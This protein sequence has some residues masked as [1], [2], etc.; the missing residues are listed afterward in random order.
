MPV[1]DIHQRLQ[2]RSRSDNTERIT[3][4]GDSSCVTQT[5]L[6]HWAQ[7]PGG[8][9]QISHALGHAVRAPIQLRKQLLLP[10]AEYHINHE[11]RTGSQ[12]V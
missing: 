2:S 11:S 12:Q 8:Q 10:H 3:S 5:T 6:T 9:Q 1:R 4:N 7:G